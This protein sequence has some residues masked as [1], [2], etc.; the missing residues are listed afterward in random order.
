MPTPSSS[1][2]IIPS[3]CSAGRT[4]TSRRPPCSRSQPQSCCSCSPQ[5]FRCWCGPNHFKVYLKGVNIMRYTIIA[6]TLVA[7]PFTVQATDAAPMLLPPPVE[8]LQAMP[9]SAPAARRAPAG[10]TISVPVLKEAL[11]KGATIMAD[12]LTEKTVP[13]SQAFAS[14]VMSADDLIGQ[15]TVRSLPAGAAINRLHVRIAPA[16]ARNQLV[17]LVYRRGGVELSGRAQAL[18]DGQ[19]GQSIRIVNP[20]TRSTLFGTVTAGGTVEVN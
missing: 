9:A 19:P 3:P 5:A 8:A 2:G 16:V 6:V 13:A 10:E 12:H 11:P 1:S 4:S 7:A 17:T 14:T 18:E 15:Q 20:S